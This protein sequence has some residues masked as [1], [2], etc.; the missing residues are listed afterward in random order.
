VGQPGPLSPSQQ[1]IWFLQRYDPDDPAYRV[2]SIQRLVG[3]LEVPV[4]LRA[5]QEVVH[6]HEPLR[7]RFLA[8]DGLPAQ[9]VVADAPVP[10]DQVDLRGRVDGGQ[11]LLRLVEEWGDQP[12]DLARAPLLRA[13]LARLGDEEHLF[14]LCAH[15]LVA[16][17]W[18]MAVFRAE[19][20]ALYAAFTAGHGSPL[21]PLAAR[22]ADHVARERERAAGPRFERAVAYWTGQLTGVPALVLPTDRP[23]PARDADAPAGPRGDVLRVALPADLLGGVA[24][25]ARSQ[26]C[27]PFMVWLAAYQAL[28]CRAAGQDEVCVGSAIAGRDHSDEEALIGYFTATVAL[29]GDLSG[30]PTFAESLKQTRT[31]VIEAH[32]HGTVPFEQVTGALPAGRDRT[33]N[34]LFQTWFTMHTQNAGGHRTDWGPQVQ[35]SMPQWPRPAG[36]AVEQAP[37]DRSYDLMADFWPGEDGA[38]LALT[39]DRELFDRETIVEFAHRLR[40]LV[41]AVVTDPHQRV[42]QVSLLAPGERGSIVDSRGCAVA[43]AAR[44]VVDLFLDQCRRTPGAPAVVCDAEV[45]SYARLDADSAAVAATIRAAGL[46]PGQIVGIHLPRSAELVAALLGILRAGAAYLPLDPSYPDARVELMLRDSGAA[47]VLTDAAGASRLDG[48]A[49]AVIQVGRAVV[50]VDGPAP[51]PGAADAAYVIYTSGS[52][53]TP[54]G[55]VVEHGSL[56]ERVAWMR[57][58]Y[59]LT[60][61]DRVAQFASLSFDTHAEEVYPVLAAGGAVVLPALP[62][63]RFP[64]WLAGPDGRAVTVLDLPTAYW[65]QLVHDLR[66]EVWPP[67]LRLMIIGGSQADAAAV[68]AWRAIF[69]DRVTLVNTYGPTETTIVATATELGALDAMVRPPIGRPAAGTA[70]YVLDPDGRPV[71]VGMP[72]ELC[73]A[74]AG[75]ARGYLGRP[76]LTG[77]VFGPDPFGPPGSRMFRTADRARLRRDGRLEYL[78]RLDRQLKVRG[79]RIE[80]AEIEAA[81]TGHAAVA[82]AL[83]TVRG[84]SLVA[85]LVPAPG[86]EPATTDL[87]AYLVRQLPAYLVPNAFVVLDRL[88]LTRSGK[89]DLDALPAPGDVSTEERRYVEPRTDAEA[90]VAEIWAEVLGRPRVGALDD[91]F[92]LGGHSLLATR[93]IARLRAET[94]VELSLRALFATPTVAGVAEEVERLLRAEIDALSDDEVARL[95]TEPAAHR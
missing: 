93:V 3:R 45:R 29:R 79:Y 46:R 49:P 47:A 33:R 80:P 14:V 65:H 25:L 78:G 5:I 35:A 41:E 38:E 10:V 54:K 64:E 17:G 62:P 76:E 42:S 26:R 60:A 23:R 81:L 74:G 28:L 50:P 71:P 43:G 95:L 51:P 69:A 34:P 82:Q 91:F 24:R 68:R 12:F 22:Y 8:A 2:V 84:D 27:T 92:E 88:P 72:G 86:A 87:R 58:E 85:Y 36:S 13:G 83:V 6:R 7:T 30:D 37:L 55:V 48:L 52:T 11:R 44:T 32:S 21:P 77:R 63:E 94:D 19:L 1:R 75:V 89:P 31:A 18:S 66:P 4:L 9:E 15:H 20:A 16:D 53:G 73:L 57:R 70:A 90:L 56:A 61:A 67:G 39:Y 59:G 40:R